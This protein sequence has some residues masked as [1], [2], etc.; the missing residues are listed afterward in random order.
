[1]PALPSSLSTQRLDLRRYA[2]EDAAWYAAMAL[3]NRAHLARFESG[4]AAMSIASEADARAAIRTFGEMADAGKAAFLG[5][6][7]RQDGAF[8]GQVYV[9]V[10]HPD[11][12]GYLVGYF[13]DEAHL[14]QGYTVEAAAAVVATLFADCDARRVGLWCDDTNLAS[15][16]IARRLG[17]RREGHLRADKRHADGTITGSLCYGLLR[18]EFLT[19]ETLVAVQAGRPTAG[20][21]SERSS[22]SK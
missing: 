3:R 9:G 20:T 17:M 13:C 8:V 22:R 10:G 1:M 11:L 12:P 19:E 21:K 16:R 4:N 7:R 18:E 2:A 5:V 6:F 14:R 15:Q